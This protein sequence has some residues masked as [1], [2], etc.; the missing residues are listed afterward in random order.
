MTNGTACRLRAVRLL[1]T[2]VWAVFAGCIVAIPVLAWQE[3]F[4]VA[5][6]LAVL[7]L[8]EVVVLWLNQWSCPLTSIAARYTDDRRANFD[9]YLPE[10]LARYNKQIFG[11]LYVVGVVYLAVMYL[12][13]G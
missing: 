4:G 10:W 6:I 12:C 5:A 7:V 8:G 3:R 11:P 9:I 13:A 1:H 2:A